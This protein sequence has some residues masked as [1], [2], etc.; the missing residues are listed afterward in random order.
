MPRCWSDARIC[1]SA[2]KRRCRS[3]GV[4]ARAQQL[5]R[6]ALLVLSVVSLGQVDDAHAAA[7]KLAQH[8]I[9]ADPAAA[10]RVSE[11]AHAGRDD[12]AFQH[13]FGALVGRDQRV[14]LGT[15]L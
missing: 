14:D 7:A 11:R 8:A 3:L 6:D 9:G 1:R 4:G 15:K 12:I 5:H 10:A 13:A 2:R